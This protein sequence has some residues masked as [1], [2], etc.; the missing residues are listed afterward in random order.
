MIVHPRRG[1][2]AKPAPSRLRRSAAVRGQ[3]P[4]EGG[5]SWIVDNFRAESDGSLIDLGRG[6]VAERGVE[7]LPVVEDLDVT[8]ELRAR[9]VEALPSGA[10]Y[11]LLLQ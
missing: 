3:C 11:R 7:A 5:D 9:V 10:V 8:V 6:P 1:S 2:R 4:R